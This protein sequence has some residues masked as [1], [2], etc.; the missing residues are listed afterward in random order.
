MISTITKALRVR[1]YPT[2]KQI[3]QIDNTINCCRFVYNHMLERSA[4]AYQRRGQHLSY[5]DMQNLLPVMK[6]YLPWLKEAD[7]QALKYA[8]RQLTNAFDKFFKKQAGYPNFKSKRN[9]VQSYTS[10][11]A[12][13]I[14]S[15][16]GRIKIPC[17]GWVATPDKRTLVGNICY[18][19]V[20]RE[21]DKYF[22]SITYK[23][24][25]DIP[26]KPLDTSSSIGLDYKSDGLYVDSEGSVAEMPHFYRKAK[27]GIAKEQQKLSKKIGARKGEKPSGNF[28]R[29]L[30]H[31][32]KKTAKVANQRKDFLH[33]Q[34]TAIAKRYDIVCVEDLNMK[35]MSNKGFGNGKA[36]LDNGYG[37]FLNMLG[38][39]LAW[40]GK[41]LIRIDKWY[42]SSQVC[43]C[44]GRVHK[45]LKDL[46]IRRWTCPDCGT[47]HD[48][49]INAAIN[50]KN[51][52]IKLF[53]T[54]NAT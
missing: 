4:K 19:T 41:Q 11:N 18:A 49:D 5:Y 20:T 2:D 29:Q 39:K 50:I 13:A 48:R 36:T 33:K 14:Y 44:C 22:A 10:T 1:I 9:G 17:I 8:C 7:S 6:E 12:T 47:V 35:A 42:P 34:S 37:M 32:Q 25:I 3:K 46:S 27:E 26:D 38:Y 43:S 45:E 24:D 40:Q 21:H 54:S 15:E 23:T 31:L 53:Q 30:K 28:K 16:R 51:E 52:G